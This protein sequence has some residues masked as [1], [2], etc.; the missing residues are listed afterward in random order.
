MSQSVKIGVRYS[1]ALF[2][3]VDLTKFNHVLQQ[4]QKKHPNDP[5]LEQ[6][7]SLLLP[8]HLKKS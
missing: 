2:M 1:K 5:L 3:Q 8:P 4:L 7:K 6:L